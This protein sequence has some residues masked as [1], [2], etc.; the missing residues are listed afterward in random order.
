MMKEPDPTDDLDRTILETFDEMHAEA[1]VTPIFLTFPPRVI[2]SVRAYAK[3]HSLEPGTL[4]P[5][6]IRA[7]ENRLY[8]FSEAGERLLEDPDSFDW[9]LEDPLMCVALAFMLKHACRCAEKA[10]E[11]RSRR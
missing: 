5:F 9:P 4:I 10:H 6:A 3:E 11:T 8:E 7:L 2:E 1:R